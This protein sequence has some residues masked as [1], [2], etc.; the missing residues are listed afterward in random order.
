MLIDWA[1]I[2]FKLGVAQIDPLTDTSPH[3]DGPITRDTSRRSTIKGVDPSLYGSENIL[4]LSDSQQMARFH[5][6]KERYC[7]FQNI[8][9]ILF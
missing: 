1:R 4:N 5:R 6:W 2:I 7:P 3:K 8:M 9:H